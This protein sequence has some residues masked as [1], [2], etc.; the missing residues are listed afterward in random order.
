MFQGSGFRVSV[1]VQVLFFIDTSSVAMTITSTSAKYEIPA[2]FYTSLTPQ[3][4][5]KTQSFKLLGSHKSY[6]PKK[7]RLCS[8]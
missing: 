3:S 1:E 6:Y 5:T 8:A 7:G 4:L 2:T